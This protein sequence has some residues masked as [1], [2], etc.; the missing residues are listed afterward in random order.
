MNYYWLTLRN[1]KITTVAYSPA[2][3]ERKI[4]DYSDFERIMEHRTAIPFTMRL[5]DVTVKKSLVVGDVS[6]TFYDY[7][8]SDLVDLM[9]EKMKAV[10]ESHL[11][12]NEHVE[13]KEVLVEGKTITKTYYFPYF[14]EELDILNVEESDII[15]FPDAPSFYFPRVACFSKDK[16]SGL[17]IFHGP[18]SFWRIPSQIYVSSAIKKALKAADI[19]EAGYEKAYIK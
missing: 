3:T 11:T 8:P 15:R 13:W 4:S 9:S 6:D 1:Y 17:S 14:T 16:I 12:G 5:H 18:G 10:I 2:L 19:P 7:Q